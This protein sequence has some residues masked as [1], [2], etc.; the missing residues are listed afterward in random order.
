MSPYG[1]GDGSAL[2]DQF[3]DTILCV[4]QVQ[5]YR[6]HKSSCGGRPNLVSWKAY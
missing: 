4:F 2:V 6:K 1:S 5:R 3:R